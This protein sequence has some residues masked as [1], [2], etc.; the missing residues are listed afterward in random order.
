[1]RKPSGWVLC[2][3]LALTACS[4]LLGSPGGGVPFVGNR[5]GSWPGGIGA[6]LRFR[7]GD[8]VLTLDEV[9]S[10][11]AA[12]SAGLR[13]GDRVIAINGAPVSGLRRDQVVA[14]LRGDVG[15]TVTLRVQRD[16]GERDFTVERAPYRPRTSR[17]SSPS[18]PR[19][20]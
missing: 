12:A 3:Y 17:E 14:R 13:R 15:T 1:V 8:G 2:A 18:T 16:A 11:G 9:P 7:E 4:S 10:G 5:G 6:V 19:E 20:R